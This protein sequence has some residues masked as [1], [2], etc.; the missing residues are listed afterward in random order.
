[1]TVSCDTPNASIHYTTD[2]TD[3]TPDDPA[4]DS[5]GRVYVDR[6]Q[7]IKAAA[8]LP[9]LAPSGVARA[10]Y[11]VTGAVAAG[12]FASFY[13]S[14]GVALRADGTVVTWTV[15]GQAPVPGLSDVVGV[16]AGTQHKLALRADGS[17]WAWGYNGYGQV[18]DGTNEVRSA[19]TR[20]PGLPVVKAIAAGALH[21]LALCADGTLW[22]WG[23]NASGQLGD[24]TT[25]NRSL[26]VPV[27][28]LSAVVAVA[29]GSAHTLAL[30]SDG[31]VWAFGSNL[32]G[33]LG[34]GTTT[35]RSSPVRV[36][37]VSGVT[38][39]AAGYQSVALQTSGLPGGA[40][41]VWGPHAAANQG[42]SS[43][44][45]SVGLTD[46]WAI[47][48]DL[49]HIYAVRL[50]GSVWSWVSV[51]GSPAR[52]LMANAIGLAGWSLPSALM[53]DGTIVLG[54]NATSIPGP[55]LVENQW[56]LADTDGD[57]LSNIEEY[58]RGT[59]PLLADSNG[60]GLDDGTTVH[61]GRD[62]LS[63]D[64]DGDGVPNQEELRRG[65][66]PL[67]ADTDGDGVPDGIDCFPLDPTRWAC[68]VDP[69]DHTPPVIMLLEPA[70][71]IP[72]P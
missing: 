22:A 37:G 39:I 12:S 31:T 59:D 24:G 55:R 30:R 42:Y 64:S 28:G 38:A 29:A 10:D 69:Q 62:P 57:G 54:E 44:P 60:D 41:W 65:T 33:L 48:T 18:G 70:N 58:R 40:V 23:Y 61:L 63:L 34:D 32:Q 36:V 72:L 51:D 5:G 71:A 43:H 2:G 14:D 27:S 26:P 15:S 52:L 4:V 53:A 25:T 21:S 46:V 45:T 66:D 6:A 11:V 3:P 47:G 50:D 7:I 56:L 16:A 13:L 9:G 17:V 67:R 49:S 1:M 8:F 19:P 68:P 35:D 20:V